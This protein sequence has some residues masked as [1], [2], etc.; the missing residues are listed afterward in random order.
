MENCKLFKVYKT[1]NCAFVVIE[2]TD[3]DFVKKLYWNTTGNK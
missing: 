3:V 1:F 2:R